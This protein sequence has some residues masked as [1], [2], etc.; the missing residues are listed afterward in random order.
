M[1]DKLPRASGVYQIRNTITGD[2]Y[3]GST[4]DMRQRQRN[5]LNGLRQRKSTHSL[6]QRGWDKY[7]EGVYLRY[8]S[9][10]PLIYS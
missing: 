5:H 8:L 1:M 3:I 6:L 7:G 2:C 4:Q 9:C 10:V